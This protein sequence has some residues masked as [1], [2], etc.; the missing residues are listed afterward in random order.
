V[1]AREL[2]RVLVLMKSRSTLAMIEAAAMQ[3]IFPSPPT[4][5]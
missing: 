4:M 1:V 5:A 2:A 3:V